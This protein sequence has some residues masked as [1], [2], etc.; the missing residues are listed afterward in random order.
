MLLQVAVFP[1]VSVTLN[2]TVGLLPAWLQ[3]NTLGVT[4]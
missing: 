3:V 2:V 4:E 1:E